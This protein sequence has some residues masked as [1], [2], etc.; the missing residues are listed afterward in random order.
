MFPECVPRSEPA[1]QPL[2]RGTFCLSRLPTTTIQN[3]LAENLLLVTS[4]S[5]VDRGSWRIRAAHAARIEGAIG[6]ML[7]RV[8][9]F[10]KEIF[11]S[12]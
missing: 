12:I 6:A 2:A 5:G 8:L 1:I 7:D 9:S 11:L 10:R 3:Q 4:P